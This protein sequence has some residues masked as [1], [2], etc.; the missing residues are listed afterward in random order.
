MGEVSHHLESL[1]TFHKIVLAM[2]LRLVTL[3]HHL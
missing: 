2:R 3:P 1:A